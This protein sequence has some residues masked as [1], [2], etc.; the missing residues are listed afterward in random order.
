MS[1]PFAELELLK[2]L[3]HGSLGVWRGGHAGGKALWLLHPQLMPHSG[4]GELL[5]QSAQLRLALHLKHHLQVR[6]Q[7]TV[8]AKRSL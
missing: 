2:V 5:R 3:L 8:T 6:T 1:S 7:D 4:L